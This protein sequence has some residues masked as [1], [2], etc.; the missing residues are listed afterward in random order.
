MSNPFFFNQGPFKIYEIIDLLSATSSVKNPSTEIYDIRDLKSAYEGTI[1]F[2]HSK[3]YKTFAN[4]TEASFC[5]T[6]DQLK[7]EISKNCCA[8]IVKN[9]LISVA[10]IT[11]FFIQIQ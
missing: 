11:K 9:V 4:N 3:K 10:K 8:L 5:I 2:L 1:T 6:T 7:N